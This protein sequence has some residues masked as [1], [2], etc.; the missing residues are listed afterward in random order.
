ML[1]LGNY[2]TLCSEPTGVLLKLRKKLRSYTV[3]YI[4]RIA[5]T[6]RDY[7]FHLSSPVSL[8]WGRRK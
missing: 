7:Q 2:P 8:G 5:N 4:D 1:Y 6:I 3:P